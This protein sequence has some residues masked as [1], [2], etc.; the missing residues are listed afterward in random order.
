MLPDYCIGAGG[1]VRTVVVVSTEPIERAERIYLDAH[2]RTS[3]QLTGWLAAHR[4]K[5]APEWYTL[6]DYEQVNRARPGDAFLLIGD[7]VFDYEDRFPTPTIWPPSG[8][9]P[10]VCRSPSPYGSPAR[11]LP[12]K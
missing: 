6:T 9:R 3:V 2:S 7:K 4:W 8:G 5:I 1:P 10:P 12:T 11:A